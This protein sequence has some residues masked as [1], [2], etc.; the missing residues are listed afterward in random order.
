MTILF[1]YFV[2]AIQLR[3]S[4]PTRLKAKL[5]I[6]EQKHSTLLS[7]LLSQSKA[8]LLK[9]AFRK[10]SCTVESEICKGRMGLI[11]HATSTVQSVFEQDAPSLIGTN[12]SAFI[13]RSIQAEHTELIERWR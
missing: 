7:K 9:L 5:K 6:L 2:L 3:P 11:K 13:P 4:L 10:D 1:S 12:I 8:N